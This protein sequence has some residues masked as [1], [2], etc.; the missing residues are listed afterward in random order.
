MA[1]PDDIYGK[2]RGGSGLQVAKVKISTKESFSRQT[3]RKLRVPTWRYYIRP[4]PS[5]LTT[6]QISTPNKVASERFKAMRIQGSRQSSGLEP[7][8]NQPCRVY[9]AP[10][11]VNNQTVLHGVYPTR[12]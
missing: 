9:A 6:Q 7:V 5:S 12:E 1:D 10:L 3:T 8:N 4:S 11:S 2:C